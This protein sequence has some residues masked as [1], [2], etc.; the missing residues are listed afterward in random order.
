MKTRK[1]II[2]ELLEEQLKT[3]INREV[4]IMS[5]DKINKTEKVSERFDPETMKY[6]DVKATEKMKELR[7]AQGID[8]KRLETLQNLLKE[9]NEKGNI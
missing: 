8:N 6:V 1:Q 5:L 3:N 2:E 9:E 7:D 4:A